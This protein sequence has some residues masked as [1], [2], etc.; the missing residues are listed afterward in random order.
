V[1]E[2]CICKGHMCTYHTYTDQDG[3]MDVTLSGASP[4]RPDVYVEVDVMEGVDLYSESN[5]AWVAAKAE[6]TLLEHGVGLH[7]DF[8]D[9]DVPFVAATPGDNWQR[10]FLYE[11]TPHFTPNRRHTHRFMML[12]N[13]F[14]GTPSSGR[15]EFLG[16]RSLVS[17]VR[18]TCTHT[19][20]LTYIE[21]VY[22]YMCVCVYSCTGLLAVGH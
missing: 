2:V 4:L 10:D 5:L 6:R 3:K 13:Q 17:L 9:T 22:S 1:N 7:L 14:G 11:Y 20:I 8:D 15:A 16:Q 18:T 21:C 12:M 19:H